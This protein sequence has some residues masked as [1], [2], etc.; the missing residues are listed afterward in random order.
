[1]PAATALSRTLAMDILD[2]VDSSIE[3]GLTRKPRELCLHARDE[4]AA[5]GQ[6]VIAPSNESE[7]LFEAR[8]LAKD[9]HDV[10]AMAKIEERGAI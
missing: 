6:P 1:M 10:E 4:C 9:S 7:E 8:H 2:G 5:C 3:H